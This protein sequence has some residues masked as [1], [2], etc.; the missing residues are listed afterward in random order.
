MA[1]A[2][3]VR[4]TEPTLLRL[5]RAGQLRVR[6]LPPQTAMAEELLKDP[7]CGMRMRPDEAVYTSEYQGVLYHFC[8]EAC[9]R[10]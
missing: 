1:R 4:G 5:L 8:S 3:W 2:G 7:V 10:L 9:K 6:L